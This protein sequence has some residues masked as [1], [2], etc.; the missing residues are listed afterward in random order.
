MTKT[1]SKKNI[2]TTTP[3]AEPVEEKATTTPEPE[4]KSTK[5]AR[6]KRRYKLHAFQPEAGRSGPKN[7]GSYVSV[8]PAGA[9][10]KAANRWI[11]P[12][13]QFGI[14]KKFHLREVGASG[15]S[16][17]FEFY[18]KRVKLDTPKK[19]KRGDKVIEVTSKVVI[20]D[21]PEAIA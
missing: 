13:D 14:A 11:V 5:K 17:I 18:A 7:G 3:D 15:E 6:K 20:V 10:R 12:K 2:K 21:K 1:K 9:A 4:T 16:N 19:Y 8:S